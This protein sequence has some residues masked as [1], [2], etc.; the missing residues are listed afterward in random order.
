MA[1]GE[2]LDNKTQIT[3]GGRVSPVNGQYYSGITVELIQIKDNTEYVCG[4]GVTDSNGYYTITARVFNI[5]GMGKLFTHV[6]NDISSIINLDEPGMEFQVTD[7]FETYSNTPLSFEEDILVV[8]YGDSTI[9]GYGSGKLAHTYSSS[10]NYNVTIYGIITE[11]NENAFLGCSSLKSIIIPGSVN[12]L[13]SNSFN[14]CDNLQS[15]IVVNGVTS[16]GYNCFGACLKLSSVTLPDTITTLSRSCFDS[17]IKL[18]SIDIPS[19]VTSMG[20]SCFSECYELVRVN[21]NWESSDDILTYDNTW[22]YRADSSLKLYIPEGT[23]SL[24][25]AKGYPS[26]ML[27]EDGT[28]FD[29]ISVS[30][31]QDVLSYAD[32]DSTVLSAQLTNG[33]QAVSVSGESVTFEV[34]KQSDDSLVETLTDTTDN[35]GLASVEYFGKGTGDLYIEV[36]CRTLSKTYSNIE[37]IRYANIGDTDKSSDFDL[38]NIKVLDSKTKGTVNIT[39]D[40][41]KYTITTTGFGNQGL[42]PIPKLN[43]ISSNYKFSVI[44]KNL[45]GLMVFNTPVVLARVEAPIGRE[46]YSN[47]W[48]SPDWHTVGSINTLDSNTEYELQLIVEGSTITVKIF[49]LNGTLLGNWSTSVSALNPSNTIYLGIWVNNSVSTIRNLKL[50]LI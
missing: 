33:G 8:N 21:F 16:I 3:V 43:G 27:I 29:D 50:K 26:S 41:N 37:D 25:V 39:H 46:V 32:G 42:I 2:I 22:F 10:N 44:I 47:N 17:C 14:S 9:E 36:S 11:I 13:E 38:A 35:T 48:N 19:S 45:G 6:G 5:N 1:G 34:R 28:P 18:S 49:D 20:Q 7:D 24:Y 30:S 4:S 23:T 31:T 12:V 40:N 15:V